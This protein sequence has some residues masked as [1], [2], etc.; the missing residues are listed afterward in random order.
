MASAALQKAKAR[1]Q[2]AGKLLFVIQNVKF[3]MTALLIFSSLWIACNN[4]G[5]NG[6]W[7]APKSHGAK[8]IFSVIPNMNT[9]TA[10]GNAWLAVTTCVISILILTIGFLQCISPNCLMTATK[11]GVHGV[12]AIVALY[13]L[14]FSFWIAVWWIKSVDTWDSLV[15]GVPCDVTKSKIMSVIRNNSDI[16]TAKLSVKDMNCVAVEIFMLGLAIG[17]FAAAQ[18][19]ILNMYRESTEK[20]MKGNDVFKRIGAHKYVI[21]G[22]LVCLAFL[23]GISFYIGEISPLPNILTCDLAIGTALLLFMWKFLSSFMEEERMNVMLAE[24]RKR[25]TVVKENLVIYD[26]E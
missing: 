7:S 26:T 22:H 2:L 24:R 13:L 23:L 11:P 3:C 12:K 15:E 1:V 16:S 19:Y 20:Y 25:G 14:L 18:I 21:I 10:D 17:C 5:D 9:L 6:N 4:S 8:P